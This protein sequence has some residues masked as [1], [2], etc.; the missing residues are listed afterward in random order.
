MGEFIFYFVILFFDIFNQKNTPKLEVKK[1]CKW[2]KK[3]RKKMNI[4]RLNLKSANKK[5]AKFPKIKDLLGRN[6]LE[7]EYEK[8]EEQ[9]NLIAG[10]LSSSDSRYDNYLASLE[11]LLN[12][13]L[14]RVK[15]GVYLNIQKKLRSHSDRAN[16]IG[17]ISEL[18]LLS[19]FIRKNIEVDYEVSITDDNKNIDIQLHLN[20]DYPIYIEVTRKSFSDAG[21]RATNAGAPFGLA[22]SPYNKEEYFRLHNKIYQKIPKLTQEDFTFIALDMTDIPEFGGENFAPISWV[23]E[24]T[25]TGLHVNDNIPELD[26]KKSG[27]IREMVDGVIWYEIN[28]DNCLEIFKRGIEINPH[29]P[30]RNNECMVKFKELWDKPLM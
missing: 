22:Y 10:W 26:E 18:A 5:L 2:F 21:R 3:S 4:K 11:C 20:D 19:F 24:E 1:F 7:K 8:D 15:E 13:L 28:F 12:F 30:H 9:Y 23:I 6:W 27:E 17:M 29:S 14:P 16:I 25:F